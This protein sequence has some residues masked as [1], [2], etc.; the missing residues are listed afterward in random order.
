MVGKEVFKLLN[1]KRVL[2][3]LIEMGLKQGICLLFFWK[4]I[5]TKNLFFYSIIQRLKEK[6]FFLIKLE[7]QF[8]F[9]AKEILHSETLL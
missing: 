8:K 1:W 6:F 4:D 7:E 3:C 5:G 2:F 9:V